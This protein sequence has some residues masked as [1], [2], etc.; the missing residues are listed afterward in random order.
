M[1]L[2]K[3]RYLVLLLAVFFAGCS[4]REQVQFRVEWMDGTQEPA[5][6]LADQ[7][8]LVKKG[9]RLQ[10]FGG[11]GQIVQ[12]PLGAGSSGATQPSHAIKMRLHFTEERLGVDLSSGPANAGEDWEAKSVA[13]TTDEQAEHRFASGIVARVLVT[14]VR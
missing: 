7:T 13:L 1:M 2:L 10:F 3:S 8:V 12:F 14:R 6:R 11:N 5:R 4:A 9:Q